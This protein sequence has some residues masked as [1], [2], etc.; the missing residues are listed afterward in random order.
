[1]GIDIPVGV[2]E[3]LMTFTTDLVALAD[4]AERYKADESKQL[5]MAEAIREVIMKGG[6]DITA[7]AFVLTEGEGS[8]VGDTING[9]MVTLMEEVSAVL[10]GV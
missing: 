4:M 1:M 5:L 9:V 8:G 6:G 3:R 10:E 2:K 7:L